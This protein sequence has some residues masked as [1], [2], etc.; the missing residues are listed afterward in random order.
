MT[1]EQYQATR[2]YFHLLVDLPP[3]QRA[4]KIEHISC[5]EIRS[6]ICRLLLLNDTQ[7]TLLDEPLFSLP[8]TF[9]PGDVVGRF[10]ITRLIGRGGMGEVFE[11]E[12]LKFSSRCAVKTIAPEWIGDLD[13]ASRFERETRAGRI[14]N[15][16]NVCR[17]YEYLEEQ[18]GGHRLAIIVMEFVEGETLQEIVARQ[19]PLK[20][21]SASA[22][23]SGILDGLEAAHRCGVIHRDLKPSNVMVQTSGR[24]V[25]MDFGL[26]R[27]SEDDSRTKRHFGTA[28]WMAPEQHRGESSVRSD[29]YSL[30]LVVLFM[31]TGQ[32]AEEGRQ[33][34][35]AWRAPLAK[36]T[37]IVPSDRYASVSE[38][39]RGFFPRPVWT[40]R[41]LV[42][43]SGTALISAVL[44]WQRRGSHLQVMDG[45]PLIIED[46]E[47]RTGDA[48]LDSVQQVVAIQLEQSP[49]L[50]I[51]TGPVGGRRRGLA[52]RVALHP[53]QE[54]IRIDFQLRSLNTNATTRTS[55]VAGSR[56]DLFPALYEACRWVR[57]SAGESPADMAELDL[58]PESASTGSWDA[59]LAFTRGEREARQRHAELA[60]QAYDEALRLDA[61][62]A[63]A[64][65]RRGD[66]LTS[67]GRDG[68]ALEAWRRTMQLAAQRRLSRL[69]EFRIR[70]MFASDTWDFAEAVR[71]YDAYVSYYPHD[72]DAYWFRARPLLLLG[73][74]EEA[75]GNMIKAVNLEP[76]NAGAQAE[77]ALMGSVL[78]RPEIV[79]EH[80]PLASQ[81]NSAVA[82]RIAQLI[83]F[84]TGHYQELQEWYERAMRQ[85]DPEHQSVMRTQHAHLLAE[86]GRWAESETILRNGIAFDL[87]AGLIA[88]ANRKRVSLLALETR[89]PGWRADRMTQEMLAG[90]A[91]SSGPWL[92]V[93]AISILARAG[94]PAM[95]RP[96]AAALKN[97]FPTPLS[98]YAQERASGEISIAEKRISD[99]LAHL[100]NAAAALPPA[101]PREFLAWGLEQAG[102]NTAFSELQRVVAAKGILWVNTYLERPGFWA[103]ALERLASRDPSYRAALQA[104]RARN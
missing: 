46:V 65:M 48:S 86:V 80:L 36:C 63:L 88:E 59:L 18:R 37:S 42:A 49:K 11:A 60:L 28:S 41:A 32:H 39:R 27:H 47:N 57:Q 89:L 79:Q 85:P 100:R 24:T 81:V 74:G 56:A 22:I 83:A 104:V 99:G 13:T 73:R 35:R 26:A 30:G 34:P 14:I 4:E 87:T 72:A 58:K 3:E 70:S 82:S 101:W 23:L 94:V 33:V 91:A 38:V 10:K 69:E 25:L 54:H 44:E 16:P 62:F 64:N 96:L 2:E 78:G 67:L 93:G 20:R 6:E 50:R 9:A 1:A 31:L 77:T 95:A 5:P 21:E 84:I 7:D 68:E 40:R 45:A 76:E 52:L 12:D 29:I 55:I 15:H 90:L 66:V 17:V 92:M 98:L 75:L 61:G 19:G 102:D 43:A 71:A 103:G 51:F 8:G 53:D 97:S